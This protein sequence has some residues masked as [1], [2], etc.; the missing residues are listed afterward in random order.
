M[1]GHKTLHCLAAAAILSASSW[2]FAQPASA[3]STVLA[4][5]ISTSAPSQ[6]TPAKPLPTTADLLQQPVYKNSWQKMTKS[7]KNLPAWARKGV[8]TSGPYEVINWA[9]QQYKVGRICK[10]HDCSNQFMWVAF[11]QNKK[12]VWQA[13]GMRV[14]V[15]DKPQALDNPSQFATYQWLGRPDEHIQALLKKQ[16]QQDPNWR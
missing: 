10:P 3:T 11:S 13:W 5:S 9:G 8:G 6:A 16:L 1:K 14:S 12:Q 4:S 7:Q 15:E 2:A